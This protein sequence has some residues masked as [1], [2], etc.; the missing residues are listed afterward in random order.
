[1]TAKPP[2]NQKAKPRSPVKASA[3]HQR[4]TYEELRQELE[5]RNRDLAESLQRESATANELQRLVE[6][7][8]A[9]GEILR[10]IASSSTDI[11][12]VLDVVAENA[13]RLCD[14][15]DAQIVRVEG[16]SLRLVASHG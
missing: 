14:A 13:A 1:M 15:D 3:V 11:Q 8:T 4:P 12:R 7:Q 6:Q 10:V 5:A 16:D 2:K 9:T